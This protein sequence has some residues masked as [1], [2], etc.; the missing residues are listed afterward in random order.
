MYNPCI[1]G[2]ITHYYSLDQPRA[3]QQRCL[4]GPQLLEVLNVEVLNVKRTP[5]LR[6]ASARAASSSSV[7]YT[8]SLAPAR[9]SAAI[10][11]RFSLSS[12]A[13]TRGGRLNSMQPQDYRDSARE[14]A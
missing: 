10:A 3:G 2:W 4:A 12:K 5:A 1:R 8:T 13:M 11:L 6:S 7:R 14:A 9:A